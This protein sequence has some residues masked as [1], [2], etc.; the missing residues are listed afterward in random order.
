MNKTLYK[1]DQKNAVRFSEITKMETEIPF[2]GIGIKYV[3]R[4]EEQ[5]FASRKKLTVKQGEYLLGNDFTAAVVQINQKEPVQGLC[6]DISAEIMAEVAD[7]YDLHEA[8]LKHFLLSDQFFVNRYQAMST[9]LG[10]SLL[11]LDTK[12]KGG[13]C[14]ADFINDE[15]FYALATAIVTDQRF[16]LKH[17]NKM[18]FKKM[19]TNEEV[20]RSLL[21][22]KSLI[23]SQSLQQLS[24]TQL[25]SE[26][27]ISKYHFLRMFKSTFGISPYQYQQQK[28]LELAKSELQQGRSVSDTAILHNYADVAAF[29][30]AFK[31][32]FGQAPSRFLK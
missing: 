1:D 32:A 25:A 30:K 7:Y 5:Y 22:A 6:I 23:D 4:G 9:T 3:V 13:N 17:L 29:S 12:L 21:Q 18:N 31:Q 28:R 8:D 20:L 24:I 14:R 27:G 16:V 11:A 2:S 26:I 15:H 19:Q 10:S